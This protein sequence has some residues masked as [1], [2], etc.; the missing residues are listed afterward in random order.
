[1]LALGG[2]QKCSVTAAELR[3]DPQQPRFKNVQCV[4]I[5]WIMA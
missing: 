5:R 2:F 3:L 4:D 1:M